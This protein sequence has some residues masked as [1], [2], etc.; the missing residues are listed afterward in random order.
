MN[1]EL[2]YFNIIIKASHNDITLYTGPYRKVEEHDENNKAF[3]Y[4]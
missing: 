4:K 2:R 3:S 1:F